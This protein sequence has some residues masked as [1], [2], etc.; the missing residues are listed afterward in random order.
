[1]VGVFPDEAAFGVARARLEEAGFGPEQYVVLHGESGLARMDTTGE[2]HGWMGKMFRSLQNAT[3]DE[4][5]HVR[6]YAEYLREGRYIVGVAVG[7]DEANK[8]R[9]AEALRGAAADFLIYYAKNYIEDLG[10]ND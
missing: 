6:R 2:T 10:E 9:A 1:V 7:D 3:T 4:G 8:R 5:K